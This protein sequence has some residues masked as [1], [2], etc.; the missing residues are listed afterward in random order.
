MRP[1]I[2]KIMLI[3]LMDVCI[4]FGLL[5]LSG[6]TRI[7]FMQECHAAA[8]AAWQKEFEDICSNTM[9][10]MNL[11]VAQLRQLIERCDK[12]RLTID[13]LEETQRKVYQ[14][15]LKMCRDMYVFALETKETTK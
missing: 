3:V 5:S 4:S 8:Q 14:R 2:K 12:V 15:R 13:T 10:S 9:E 6:D 7:S 11:T 1:P